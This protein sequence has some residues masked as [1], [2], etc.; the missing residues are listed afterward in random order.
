VRDG[1]VLARGKAISVVERLPEYPVWVEADA[2]RL[3]QAALIGIDN[4]INYSAAGQSI[5][6]SLG[7]ANGRAVISVLDH[8]IGVSAEE[9]PYVFERFY[10][11]RSRENRETTGSGLGLSIAK[12]IAEK[13]GGSIAM[14]SIPGERTELRIDLPLQERSES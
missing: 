10:R 2:Q 14:S 7:A 11:V 4:A 8:G 13:H 6:I 5:E 1:S 9:L 12:W 3:R